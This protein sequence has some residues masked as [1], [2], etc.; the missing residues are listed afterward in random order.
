MGCSP[1]R[2]CNLAPQHNLDLPAENEYRHDQ[3]G[4]ATRDD[5]RGSEPALGAAWTTSQPPPDHT[6]RIPSVTTGDGSRRASPPDEAAS[7]KPA[8]VPVMHDSA[9]GSPPPYNVESIQ[10][11]PREVQLRGVTVAWVLRFHAWAQAAFPENPSGFTTKE[12]V[13]T[14]VLRD[15][16]KHH[17]SMVRLAGVDVRPAR[18]FLSHAWVR[19]FSELVRCLA[20]RFR[21]QEETTS[22]WLDFC[23]LN[24]N[25]AWAGDDLMIDLEHLE[26]TVG[27]MERT[28]LVVDPNG[29]CFTRAWCLLE[30]HTAVL[31]GRGDGCKDKA[32]RLEM[33]PYALVSGTSNAAALSDVMFGVEVSS[34]Q[35]F[36]PTDRE[37]ILASIDREFGFQSF[38]LTLKEAFADAVA[39][40]VSLLPPGSAEWADM[41]HTAGAVL[42]DGGHFPKASQLLR[43]AV[44]VSGAERGKGDP[45]TLQMAN[46][47]L[48]TL[49]NLGHLQEA[50][51][52]GRD[53]LALA[54]VAMGAGDPGLPVFIGGMASVLTELGQ[55]QEA[56]QLHQEE[57]KLRQKLLPPEHPDVASTLNNLAGVLHGQGRLQHAE[58]ACRAA[59]DIRRVALGAHPTT[60]VSMANLAVILDTQDQL[61]EASQLY[62]EALALQCKTLGDHHL[63]TNRTRGSLAVLLFKQ[64]RMDEAEPLYR[65]E[66]AAGVRTLGEDHP[67]VAASWRNL[68]LLLYSRG[69]LE[70]AEALCRRA[71]AADRAV[72]G[73][74]HPNTAKSLNKMVAILAAKGS[75][76]EAETLAREAIAVNEAALGRMHTGTLESM[77]QLAEVQGKCG[78]LGEAADVL[79]E[80]LSRREA[81]LGSNCHLGLVPDLHALAAA[82][83]PLG[84]DED[85]EKLLRRVLAIYR[86][87]PDQGSIQDKAT[88]AV[89]LGSVLHS[90]GKL[91]EAE[92][93]Y[94]EGLRIYKSCPGSERLH[95]AAAAGNLAALLVSAGR[96]EEATELCQEALTINRAVLGDG[97]PATVA[98]LSNLTNIL[99]AQGKEPGAL[100]NI[101]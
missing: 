69:E 4:P 101:V 10:E 71:L 100:L 56:E 64:G 94:R 70:E 45:A 81:L 65:E 47:L 74:R 59:L 20:T 97:H 33:L 53:T 63:N 89:N 83:R 29:T 15:T 31:G 16:A 99:K 7:A 37:R 72:L 19:P 46:T 92:E 95:V 5:V 66:I 57:L 86:D 54:R 50:E 75:L 93:L 77:T 85:V 22:V 39:A 58:E 24:Q 84:R 60:A 2:I 49:C 25:Q 73:S 38:N 43:E 40:M 55:L 12:V 8:T 17:C 34:A 11:E 23:A 87:S 28:L 98:S 6:D 26:A 96:L 48:V 41:A 68:A 52:L 18:F 78:A 90:Q 51:A 82:L 91:P 67:D 3:P 44:R 61:E 79:S 88:S 27:S 76:G 13:D 14:V 80:V 21:G 42:D 62:Q 1:S 9:G 30:M 32:G 35:A 36:I